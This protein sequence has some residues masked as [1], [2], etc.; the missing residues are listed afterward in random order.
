[1][2]SKE[3][4]NACKVVETL[5]GGVYLEEWDHLVCVF[6]GHIW[7]LTHFSFM[8]YHSSW[9]TYSVMV[10]YCHDQYCTTHFWV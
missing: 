10:S 7:S 3:F 9:R 4:E 8:A 1:M 2:D 5:G 6:E